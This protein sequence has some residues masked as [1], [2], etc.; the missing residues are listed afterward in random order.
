MPR[1]ATLRTITLV[2][3]A[4]WA[5]PALADDDDDAAVPD[6]DRIDEP[7][8]GKFL[9]LGR[10]CKAERELIEIAPDSPPM[11]FDEAGT[12]GCNAWEFDIAATGEFGQGQALQTPLIEIDYGIGDNVELSL[13]L[14]Y[15]LNRVEGASTRGLGAAELGI[16]HRF[17]EDESR[18]LGLAFYPQIELAV[19]GTSLAE[20]EDGE[21][22]FDLPFVFETRL[23]RIGSGNIMLGATAGYSI[24]TEPMT[25]NYISAGLGVGVP[26]TPKLAVMV[27]GFTRQ[28]VGE[29]ADGMRKGYFKA[30]L[31]VFG[32]ITPH[33]KWFG[34]LG[35]TFG[36]SES[37][38]SSHTCM[39][40]GIRILAGGP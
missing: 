5:S 9:L 22:S 30:N 8:G 35:Q 39:S 2:C 12:I 24:T 14:P 4:V 1:I 26:V 21:M 15:Q 28:A 10:E 20:E 40:L 34:S 38:D 17:Y 23:A 31:G 3:A 13:E 29:N 33:L 16:K 36:G 27:E 37:D 32:S 25:A 6:K 18:E 19:P 11:D 7:A